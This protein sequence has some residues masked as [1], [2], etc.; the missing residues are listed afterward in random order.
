MRCS[1]NVSS[2]DLYCHRVQSEL[3][4]IYLHTIIQPI[5]AN[6]YSM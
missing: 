4:R 2:R 5:D 1:V 3:K 6:S